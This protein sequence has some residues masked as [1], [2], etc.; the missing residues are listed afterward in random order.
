MPHGSRAAIMFAAGVSALTASIPAR[1]Q[2]GDIVGRPGGLARPD[3]APRPYFPE[4][5]RDLL[6]SPSPWSA[7]PAPKTGSS[8]GVI[9]EQQAMSL[10]AAAGFTN[11]HFLRPNIDGSW[12]CYA[13]K[14]G[15]RVQATINQQ[16]NILTR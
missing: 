4:P 15:R 7:V 3:R 2:T 16:G 6:P 12:T 9:T 10:F 13:S 11:V 14:Q 1:G 8:P 5:R